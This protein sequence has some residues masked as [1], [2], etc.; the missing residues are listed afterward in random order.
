MNLAMFQLNVYLYFLTILVSTSLLLKRDCD[1][2][3]IKKEE[4]LLIYPSSGIYIFPLAWLR[5]FI[6]RSADTIM[7][8]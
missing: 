5:S 8:T 1:G 7:V 3:T 4:M 2:S 6:L